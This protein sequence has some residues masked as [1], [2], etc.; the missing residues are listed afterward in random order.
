MSLS[1]ASIDLNQVTN[2]EWLLMDTIGGQ[3]VI[4][5]RGNDV[6]NYRFNSYGEKSIHVRLEM[7][8]GEK[9][10]IER[11]ISLNEP[12]KLSRNMK[13]MDSNGAI[14]NT[15]NTYQSDI[16]AYVIEN[17]LTPPT[18]ITLDA[19]DITT[20]NDGYVLSEVL[21]KISDGKT[22]EEKRGERIGVTLDE[23]LRYTIE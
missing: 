10:D 7:G 3:S 20:S 2:I 8:N 12:L 21:W 4:C 16:K 1:G 19:R 5:T 6:C 11:K 22:I 17:T 13:V 15:S 18:D 23:P 9:Y 14:L